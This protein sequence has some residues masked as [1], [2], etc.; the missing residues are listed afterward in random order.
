[1]KRFWL[2]ALLAAGAVWVLQAPVLSGMADFALEVV[3]ARS[4]YDFSAEKVQA[5]L[6]SPLVVEGAG[7]STRGRGAAEVFAAERVAVRW[8]GAAGIFSGRF[9]EA[10]EVD[11]AALS[12]DLRERAWSGAG[13]TRGEWAVVLGRVLG[14][15]SGAPERIRI[16]GATVEVVSTDSRWV[17]D[18]VDVDLDSSRAG[19]LAVEGLALQAGGFGKVL[20]PL[21]AA[22]AWKDG[23]LGLSGM[24]FF[25]GVELREASVAFGM[26][27]VSASLGAGIFG[28]TLR[29]DVRLAG[30]GGRQI[31]DVAL[32]GSG[33]GLGGLPALLDLKGKADGRLS[34]GRF[35]FRGEAGRPTDAEASLRVVAKDFRWNERG[36]ESLEIGASLIHR[37]LLISNF[38]FRQGENS[39]AMNGEISVDEGLSRIGGAPFLW[40]LRAEVREPESLGDLL[41]V[42]V[43]GEGGSISAQGSV[44]GRAGSVD[45]FARLEAKG[46]VVD[47]VPVD[48]A[49]AE[50][51]FKKT[52]AEVVAFE[53]KSGK[54]RLAA[55]GT[56]GL[57]KPH[58]YSAKVSMALR[59]SGRYLKLAGRDGM[60][61]SLA[62]D[63]RGSG[64]ADAHYGAFEADVRD[65]VSPLTPAGLTGRFEAT[66][67]P[68]NVYFPKIEMRNGG[69]VLKSRA[70]LSGAGVNL[71]DTEISSRAGTLLSGGGFVPLDV[72][73]L[74]RGAA[75]KA[76]LA[77]GGKMYLQIGTPGGVELGELVR[78]AGQKYPIAGTLRM[79]AEVSG[80][81]AD[82]SAK[83]WLKASDFAIGAGDVPRS[84]LDLGFQAGGGAA[85]LTAKLQ[86]RGSGVVKAVAKFPL[87]LQRDAAGTPVLFDPAGKIDVAVDFPRAEL[88]LLRPFFPKLRW[89]DGEAAGSLTVSN[90]VAEPRIGGGAELV[91]AGFSFGT[92]PQPV[93][94]VGGRMVFENDTVRLEN[95]TGA[96]GGGRFEMGGACRFSK[97]WVPEFE[98]NWKLERV[99]VR[100]DQFAGLYVDGELTGSGGRDGGRLGGRLDFTGS[101]IH[102]RAAVDF[103]FGGARNELAGLRELV[104]TL[105]ELASG[106]SWGLDVGVGCVE[107]VAV[108]GGRFDGAL[109][110]SMH[111][112][113]TVENPVPVGRVSLFGVEVSAPAGSFFVM[114]GRLD[115]LPDVPWDPFVSLEAAGW[116]GG[117]E[118]GL[119]AFG[120]LS[121]G[122]WMPLADGLLPQEAFFLFERGMVFLRPGGLTP[123][124]FRILEDGSG[125]ASM[126]VV[127]DTAWSG[128]LR[129]GEGM[130]L[131]LRG[132]VMPM[133]TFLADY[134]LRWAP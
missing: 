37:R 22:A 132:P 5:G 18:G 7:V 40:N 50:V 23:G 71:N 101:R 8:R 24:E 129:F 107:P 59:E 36:W 96:I 49:K 113:G 82:F 133:E 2:G 64:S 17:L 83:G 54:D 95:V 131:A 111:L 86:T 4:G 121:E 9:V 106:T 47:G 33:I 72:F 87:G 67:S 128:G 75:W 103:G 13:G 126:R 79:D 26:D 122:R 48:A 108:R 89:L 35:T 1:M 51:L 109:V 105:G 93:D 11:G 114:D 77:E 52:Q 100:G 69:L 58:G 56:V 20:G 39:V 123:V 42:T 98:A 120:P 53:L 27:G 119:F 62:L 76:A 85:E 124:D 125:A 68:E 25:P 30:E 74:A 38:D 70:T 3:C 16:S 134:R 78:L 41:G 12:V 60:G 15:G 44:S 116:F 118:V 32:V 90:T 88:A 102:A 97:G 28:G 94:L 80:T 65:F 104:W 6:W 117:R 45:G 61:G 127:Q 110:P 91:R 19:E 55:G 34:E 99:P 92:L 112:G 29:G 21:R 73:A 63:W 43:C 84:V 10:V 31:W 81:P 130:D 115:F 14:I 57:A 66:Y 46:V